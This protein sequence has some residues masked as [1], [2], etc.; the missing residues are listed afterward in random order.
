VG[1]ATRPTPQF[2]VLGKIIAV[3]VL[4]NS[5]AF[6]QQAEER[7]QR[8]RDVPREVIPPAPWLSAED[9][10]KSFKIKNG[11]LIEC[12][13]HEPLVESPVAM[14]FGPDGRMWVV[15]MRGFMPN[16]EGKGE[17]AIPGRIVVLEDTDSD[18]K[19][20]KKTIFLDNLVMPR[21]LA[22][23]R[24]G[25]LVAEPPHLW[26]CRDTNGDSKADEKTEV[27]ANY[28]DQKNPEHNA[29]GLLRNIDNWIYSLYH[30]F[31]YRD[32]GSNWIRGPGPQR[33]Q[34]GLD[35]DD[36]GR[37]FYTG[38]SDHLRG[39][40]VPSH[41]LAGRSPG[42]KMPGITVAIA[43]D[44]ATWPGRVN[45]GVNR[46]YEPDTLRGDYRLAK[47]TA[48]CGTLIY[49][50]D[51]LGA[52]F[53]G[54][55]FVCEPSANLVRR[56]ILTEQD[57]MITATN[58]YVKDEFLTSTDERFRPV[59]LCSGPDGAIYV[60]D[61]YQ[62]ILQHRIYLSPWLR[63]QIESRGL[64]KPIHQ[65][66]IYRIARVPSRSAPKVQLAQ[67]TSHALVQTLRHGDAWWR[68]TAQRL[69]VE[70]NDE[71]VVPALNALGM[72]SRLQPVEQSNASSHISPANAGTPY[73]STVA[74][75]HA[76]WTLE[77][78]G[79]LD[80]AMIENALKDRDARV[81]SAAIRLTESF[82]KDASGE[83]LGRH[84]AGLTNDTAV[85]QMQLALT[86]GTSLPNKSAE[87]TL[88]ALATNSPFR[89]VR[90]LAQFSAAG[91][92]QPPKTTNVAKARPLTPEEEKLFENG[93]SVYEA[94][95]LAC[96][97]PHGMGQEG[98]AP[99]LVGTDWVAASPGRL[100]RIVLHG[101][102][103]PLKVKDQTYEMDMPALGVLDDEQIASALTYVRRE[104][105]H[106]F[107]AV[108]PEMVKK[109]RQDTEKR[110]EA[111][112]EPELLKIP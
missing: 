68:D 71:S 83:W 59:N 21:A 89:L 61:M 30:T 88:N 73:A 24:D 65:G 42:T 104:W 107:S 6:A 1:P 60:V 19:M 48:A 75:L 46:A 87:Q 70:R 63:R 112:T 28:G 92:E 90:E 17:T 52:P 39:D 12:V 51:R 56:N 49:R 9:A 103:G 100:I 26:F 94:T 82:L 2:I 27:A 106:A 37:L 79:K 111:W 20:D 38:N 34:W 3:V 29:N 7:E 15:E 11:L 62:G 14:Q 25:A 13:A 69:L 93:K 4:L 101:V 105:G 74:R 50:S 85:V 95:C 36:F 16:I 76:L 78:M 18:G 55:A 80:A 10:L 91:A 35:H 41:Y 5:V 66:R 64:D 33:T 67:A 98:L 22:L 109:V 81:R 97:Q 96:H 8:R 110:E 99:P 72:E 53:Y 57:G 108:T 40:L 44:Q 102:R 31:R 77:G 47:F 84:L 43:R 86:L 45:P 54:N 23:A 58:A 32:G